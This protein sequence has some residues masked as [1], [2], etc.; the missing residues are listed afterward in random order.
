MA[1][2]QNCPRIPDTT[3]MQ[4]YD[5]PEAMRGFVAAGAAVRHEQLLRLPF[6][7]DP[8]HLREQLLEQPN[9]STIVQGPMFGA[10]YE[11][12]AQSVEASRRGE[13]SPLETMTRVVKTYRYLGNYTLAAA[14]EEGREIETRV[15]VCN[16]FVMIPELGRMAFAGDEIDAW[17]HDDGSVT[18]N[19]D[20]QII[21]FDPRVADQPNWQPLR[22]IGPP[23]FRIPLN[24]IDPHRNIFRYPVAERLSPEQHQKW[25]SHFQRTL[26]FI[27]ANDPHLGEMV[28]SSLVSIVPAP[29]EPL[30]HGKSM[31]NS[32]ALGVIGTNEI[33]DHVRLAS[34]HIA[35]GLRKHMLLALRANYPLLFRDDD[36]PLA[37][38]E[39]Y[40]PNREGHAVAP[41]LLDDSFINIAP[42]SFFSKVAR[43]PALREYSTFSFARWYGESLQNLEALEAS[44]YATADTERLMRI[45]RQE[46]SQLEEFAVS[47]PEH[48][49]EAAACHALDGRLSWRLHSVLPDQH[50]IKTIKEAWQNDET[51]PKIIINSTIDSRTDAFIHLGARMRY[52]LREVSL[53]EPDV[54]Q[55]LCQGQPQTELLGQPTP[56]DISYT[57]GEL[58]EA[59]NY[60]RSAIHAEPDNPEPWAGFALTFKD[61]ASP[62][63][64]ALTDQPEI[65]A[66]VYAALDN[67]RLEPEGIAAWL[68][69][70][71]HS[72]I[73]PDCSHL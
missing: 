27:Q 9:S 43:N 11:S 67:T 47:I 12:I 24:D 2:L 15:Q 53:K 64:R 61:Q 69:D 36:D 58:R 55:Q 31:T 30:A 60:F 44:G 73:P 6:K 48:I 70:Q 29:E 19:S 26:D 33:H 72:S 54:F 1:E 63:A 32:A 5:S 49:Q 22:R 68:A 57:R 35:F 42:A 10:W 8:Q 46:L 56:G 45:M 41:F 23:D 66:A 21:T 38:K 71:A 59:R 51:C 18:L 65:I 28:R 62:T 50:A 17:A 40:T 13:L 14:L 52:V 16:G 7:N 34:H 20:E 4:L 39:V 37:A 25:N 3:A